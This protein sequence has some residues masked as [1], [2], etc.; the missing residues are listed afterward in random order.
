M[1]S[2]LL[3]GLK[4]KQTDRDHSFKSS[5]G[6]FI[7]SHY[8]ATAGERVSADIDELDNLRSLVTD[9]NLSLQPSTEEAF[10][11]YYGNLRLIQ[12]RFSSI[13]FAFRWSDA[14]QPDQVVASTSLRAEI[15][16][17]IFNLSAFLS[18]MAI[19][20]KKDT[21]DDL[22][23]SGKF[24]M[25]AAGSL[26]YLRSELGLG[27]LEAETTDSSPEC[28]EVLESMMITQAIECILEKGA[29]AGAGK[30]TLARLA[31]QVAVQTRDIYGAL[32]GPQLQHHFEKPWQ[33]TFKVK[34]HYY[35][36]LACLYQGDHL[37]AALESSD[38]QLAVRSQVS[39]AHEAKNHMIEAQRL[40]AT[41]K[42]NS[43]I[44]EEVDRMVREVTTR[45]AELQTENA[46][47]YLQRVVPV[48]ELEQIEPLPSSALPQPVRLDYLVQ[49]I[50]SLAFKSVVPEQVTR[51]LSR[52]TAMLDKMM[53]SEQGRVDQA[54]DAC[55]LR[56]REMELPD[57]LH[58]TQPGNIS[59]VPD[60]I[61]VEVQGIEE[62]G[63][64]TSLWRLADELTKMNISISR[65][66]D[67][68]RC[69]PGAAQYA[70]KIESYANNI[71]VAKR[72]DEHSR[73]R[74]EKHESDLR[75]L[76]MAEAAAQAPHVQSRMLLVDSTE[77]TEAA[78][79]LE[80][81]MEGLRA[82]GEQRSTLIDQLKRTKDG[83]D[84]VDS[85]MA[86]PA[87]DGTVDFDAHLAKYGPIRQSITEN[88]SKQDAILNA[89]DAA[90]RVFEDSYDFADWEKKRRGMV[91][92]WRTRISAFRDIN[93][94]LNEGL[95]F[96]V[97][98]AD[99]VSM[100]KRTLLGGGVDATG[101]FG[102]IGSVSNARVG[103]RQGHGVF[104]NAPAGTPSA[105]NNLILPVHDLNKHLS[106]RLHLGDSASGT[107]DV[108]LSGYNPLRGRT[109]R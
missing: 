38:V 71:S 8:G 21:A 17:N 63:G 89:M 70:A 79:A 23:L 93:A 61:G 27:R 101:G 39:Y 6:A 86:V 35:E 14:F 90:N 37:R 99:A 46:T 11:Q 48:S 102:G 65:D 84:I 52:Y 64:V 94:S 105:P 100:L 57:R 2:A 49:P 16:S 34:A 55:S 19:N 96:Y 4:L 62:S 22:A 12:R 74:L 9:S 66:L 13:S 15:A 98:L 108:E 47:T 33:Y 53:R 32:G 68:C 60:A 7:E 10:A 36:A 87:V 104:S 40:C 45:V 3:L 29:I 50:S 109:S 91:E 56:L 81:G 73:I 59:N 103:N 76:T 18:Q 85:L 1:T 95:E 54:N 72:T 106:S 77:P 42:A 25:K 88:I 69:A 82:L 83:D 78:Q 58:A 44:K 24:F 80:I 75:G 97:T 30:G 67:D 51:D 28:L 31:A 92:R 41:I 107:D 43:A 20:C 5:L 26:A